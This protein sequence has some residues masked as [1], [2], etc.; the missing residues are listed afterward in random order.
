MFFLLRLAFW[1]TLICLL[2]PSSRE[3]GQRLISSAGQAVADMRGFCQRNPQTC[4]DMRVTMTALLA[5]LR[6][7]AEMLQTWLAQQ[8]GEGEDHAGPAADRLA[9]PIRRSGKSDPQP[10]R[11]VAKWQD[12]LNTSDKQMPWRGPA[13]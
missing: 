12:S 5:K 3:D 8:D 13:F 6:N 7:G 9:A 10:L 1:V 11:P 4:D 2:L